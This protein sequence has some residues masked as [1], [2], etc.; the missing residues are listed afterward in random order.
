MASIGLAEVGLYQEPG[1]ARV[2]GDCDC[3]KVT[4]GKSEA[5]HV[6]TQPCSGLA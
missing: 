1:R 6:L 5:G 3:R 2:L 4:G